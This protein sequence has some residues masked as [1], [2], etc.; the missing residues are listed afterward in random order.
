[1]PPPGTVIAEP[2]T[3]GPAAAGTELPPADVPARKEKRDKAE[4]DKGSKRE[5]AKERGRSRSRR[6][7]AKKEAEPPLPSASRRPKSPE[8]SPEPD[9]SDTRQQCPICWQWISAGPYSLAQHQHSSQ[10]CRNWQTAQTPPKK[11]ER[12]DHG[13]CPR[14]GRSIRV[15][16]LWATFQHYE[17]MH[18]RFTD[19]DLPPAFLTRVRAGTRRSATVA[20]GRSRT[21][22]RKAASLRSRRSRSRKPAVEIARPP[23]VRPARPVEIPRPPSVRPPS[24]RPEPEVKREPESSAEDDSAGK[25]RHRRRRRHRRAESPPPDTKHTPLGGNDKKGPP[26]GPD[27]SGSG[28]GGFMAGGGVSD[29]LIL[30]GQS[31]QKERQSTA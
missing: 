14:C 24:R 1:M 13:S 30:I 16:D 12:K 26:P 7:R 3:P 5:T 22:S 6:R 31:L 20:R 29:L 11:E 25:P 23:S 15:G 8:K 2:V 18:P 4:K 19:A 10:N 28:L 17:A 21:R 27:P 9:R